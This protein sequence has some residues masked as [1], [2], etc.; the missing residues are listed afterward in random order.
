MDIWLITTVILLIGFVVMCWAM[1]SESK[2]RE[3]TLD[4][5]IEYIRERN[6]REWSQRRGK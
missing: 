1:W 4:G 3:R 6:D 2:A 5:W